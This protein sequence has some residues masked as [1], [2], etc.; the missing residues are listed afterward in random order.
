MRWA[1]L[2][3]GAV[4]AAIGQDAPPPQVTPAAGTE[5]VVV[6][7]VVVDG[8]G[9]PVNDLTRDDFELREDGTPQPITH[10]EA[11]RVEERANAAGARPPVSTNMA[12]PSEAPSSVLAIVFDERHLLPNTLP[13]ARKAVDALLARPFRP[14][15]EVVLLATA[16]GEAWTARNEVGL[17]A[18]RARLAGLRGLRRPIPEHE[19]ITEYEAY[20]ITAFEDRQALMRVVGRITDLERTWGGLVTSPNPNIRRNRMETIERTARPLAHEVWSAVSKTTAAT[21]AAIEGLAQAL[22]PRKGRKTAVLVSDG[23][24]ADPQSPEWKRTLEAARRANLVVYG[25]DARGLQLGLELGADVGRKASWAGNEGTGLVDVEASEGSDT[26]VSETGGTVRRNTNAL[27]EALLQITDEG[28][29]YYLLG[30]RPGGPPDDKYHRLTVSVARPGLTVR[31]RKGYFAQRTLA[32]T[33]RAAPLPLRL[34]AYVGRPQ[35]AGGSHV[36]VVGE[37]DPQAIEFKQ[38]GGRWTAAVDWVAD[39]FTPGR[40]SAAQPR[41]LRLSLTDEGL[42]AA[43]QAWI[44]LGTELDVPPGA[45]VARLFVRDDKSGRSG[46]VDHVFEVPAPGALYVTTVLSD[47]QRAAGSRA[48]ALIARRTFAAGSRLLCEFEVHNAAGPAGARRVTAGHEVRTSAGEVVGRQEP[49]PL[50][51]SADGRL[52]RL[53][54]VS[55]QKAAPGRYELVVHVR[56]EVGG[57]SLELVEPFE[58]VPPAAVAGR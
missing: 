39:V 21:L 37:L 24:V 51:E 53:M 47:L 41:R 32:D 25:L 57:T 42:A 19:K 29:S 13:A 15:D 10:F 12:A 33:A 58:V 27:A 7:A 54:V 23:F 35:P 1:G 11:V 20:R 18:L 26:L 52:A 43:R 4:I 48:P 40:P 34:S 5:L 49:A 38:E 22:G 3:L 6:D 9:R 2:L 50:V 55:L 14:G 16:S 46:A 30:Y 31:A 44:P 45:H 56:D 17:A 8:D 28:R 36:Q